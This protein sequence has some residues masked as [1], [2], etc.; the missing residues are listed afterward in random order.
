MGML[1]KEVNKPE[2]CSLGEK[3]KVLI[4]YDV[5]TKTFTNAHTRSDED[6]EEEM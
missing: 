3:K 6:D 2:V 4:F 1:E 5:A